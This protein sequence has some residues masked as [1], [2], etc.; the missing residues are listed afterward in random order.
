[1]GT[2]YLVQIAQPSS[3]PWTISTITLVYVIMS[4]CVGF[5]LT[6]MIV[7]R[8]YLFRRRTTKVLGPRHGVHYTSIITI[9][10]ESSVLVYILL[11]FFVILF[12][13]GNPLANIFLS[14]LVQLQVRQMISRLVILTVVNPLVYRLL[15]RI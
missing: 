2:I 8:L 6:L 14:T 11:L 12:A 3:S 1:M 9:I 15:L 4:F 5:V 13:M 10:V 7:V